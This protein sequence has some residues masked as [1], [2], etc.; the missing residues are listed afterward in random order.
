MS[1]KE[2]KRMGK[3]YDRTAVTNLDNLSRCTYTIATAIEEFMAS[4]PYRDDQSL[5]ILVAGLIEGL[6]VGT[7]IAYSAMENSPEVD[8]KLIVKTVRESFLFM[9]DKFDNGD[10]G[11]ADD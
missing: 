5:N 6:D 1:K 10:G 9:K 7:N 4:C 8:P 3:M 2:K 11:R